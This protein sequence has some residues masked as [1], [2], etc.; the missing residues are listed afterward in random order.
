MTRKIAM[1]SRK[2]PLFET[3]AYLATIGATSGLIRYIWSSYGTLPD[4]GSKHIADAVEAV[5]GAVFIDGGIDPVMKVLKTLEVD[6]SQQK[7]T[8]PFKPSNV[9]NGEAKTSTS[10]V[11]PP[12]TTSD[13]QVGLSPTPDEDAVPSQPLHTG[14]HSVGET[15]VEVQQPAD[16][17]AGAEKSLPQAP[18]QQQAIA[19]E[20][21]LVG[22]HMFDVGSVQSMLDK[23]GKAA[24]E[25]VGQ[26][27]QHHVGFGGHVGNYADGG[28]Q[29][30]D[31][32]HGPQAPS[33]LLEKIGDTITA[34]VTHTV[35]SSTSDDCAVVEAVR[36]TMGQE[37]RSQKQ[38]TRQRERGVHGYGIAF[39][40]PT[41]LTNHVIAGRVTKNYAG[42]GARH[43]AQT[44][45]SLLSGAAQALHKGVGARFE[46]REATTTSDDSDCIALHSQRRPGS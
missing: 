32:L 4:I 7:P 11:P 29:T 26:L 31:K 2:V 10:V 45:Y 27:T 34:N 22:N 39:G 17:N 25:R 30:D 15:A 44:R 37:W 23:A 13:A 8:K 12:A 21:V 38:A 20:E 33:S 16:Q 19:P 5:L 24:A 28:L 14:A 41:A 35:T 3:N 43:E 6:I 40:R 1:T 46:P 42:M 36:L 9:S 18:H